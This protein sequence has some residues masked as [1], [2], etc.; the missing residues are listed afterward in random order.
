MK[1]K[2]KKSK[3]LINYQIKQ[4]LINQKQNLKKRIKKQKHK[5]LTLKN[6]KIQIK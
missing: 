2:I 4:D 6:L 3:Q 5:K 1:I